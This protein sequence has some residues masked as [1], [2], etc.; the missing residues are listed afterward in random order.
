[1]VSSWLDASAVGRLAPVVPLAEARL[2]S[3]VSVMS[4]AGLLTGVV[5]SGMLACWCREGRDGSP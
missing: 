1:M 5:V 2:L 3:A 4:V